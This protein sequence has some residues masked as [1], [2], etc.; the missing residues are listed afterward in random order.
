M[1][2]DPEEVLQK[3]MCMCTICGKKAKSS[4]IFKTVAGKHP[5]FSKS[6]F[7]ER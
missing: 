3:K 4:V 6:V 5:P 7:K 2:T 1:V